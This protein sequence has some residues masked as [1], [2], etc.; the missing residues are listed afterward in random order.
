[1][2]F[3]I[4]EQV[5]DAIGSERMGVRLSPANTWNVPADSDTR[6]L[7]DF[8]IGALSVISSPTCICGKLRAT[9]PAFPTWWWT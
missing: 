4:V 5:S 6:A 8:V 2:L 9:C 3:E 1:L 7:Y